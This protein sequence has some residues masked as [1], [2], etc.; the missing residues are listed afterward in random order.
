[1]GVEDGIPV[2]GTAGNFRHTAWHEF[3]HSFVNPATERFGE[4]VGEF[5][6]LFEPIR[7]EMELQAYGEWETCVNEHIVRAVTSRLT[8]RELG[9]D[10]GAAALMNEKR[11]GFYYVEALSERLE[12]YER[13]RETY[14]TFVDFYPELLAVFRELSERDLGPEFYTVPFTG[15]IN[16]AFRGTVVLVVPTAESD[17]DAQN[18]I[19][20]Y[21]KK[22]RDQM[23]AESEILTDREAL[24][25]DLSAVSVVAYGTPE[26]NLWTARVLA[27]MP[28]KFIDDRIE[29]DITLPG[30]DLRLISAWPNPQNPEKAVV[31][32][33]AQR[34]R[35]VVGINSVFHGPTDFVVARGSEV[36]QSA[37]YLKKDDT[38]SLPTE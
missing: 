27:T 5:E 22:V 36:L 31:I 15:T 4:Q 6:S 8:S 3:S 19:Q 16:D 34:A 10:Q 30:G 29:T 28:V 13:E 9:E 17:A 1:V 23:F 37:D 35:D 21:V 20:D 26:G 32:Y 11:L 24:E 38:W 14:A 2:F 25:R 33:T 7:D 18:A 12:R